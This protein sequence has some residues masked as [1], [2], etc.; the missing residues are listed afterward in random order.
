MEQVLQLPFSTII[1]GL[2]HRAQ[3]SP[4]KPA[5]LYPD[6]NKNFTEYTSL[7]FK[8][9]NNVVNHF[10]EK[11]YQALP[12]STLSAGEPMTC[13]IL[14]TGG[15][16]YL[17]SEYALLKIPN[18]IM[19]PISARN[20]PAAIEHLI[21]ETKT[22]LI[23]TTRLH[24]PVLDKIRDQEEFRSLQVIVLN[25]GD[26]VIEEMLQRKDDACVTMPEVLK[27]REKNDSDLS[28]VVMILHR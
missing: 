23:L 10:A 20:S 9:Y 11:I 5:I 27:M 16:E 24:V 4:N 8:Q 21:R 6:A 14:A 12:V 17:L 1:G 22:I 13:G 7:T 26:F 3:A 19:F 28:K 25:E 15:I 18:V 2:E